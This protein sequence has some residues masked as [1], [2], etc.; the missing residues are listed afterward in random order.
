MARAV[1]F[2]RFGPTDELEVVRIPPP[3]PGPG[4]VRVHVRAAGLNPVDGKILRS[5]AAAAF[6][7][8]GG[9]PSGNGNDFAGVVDSVGDGVT[10]WSVGDE[11]YGGRRFFAQADFVVIAAE[12]LQRKPADLSWEQA[13]ALDIVGRTA[14][15]AVRTVAPTAADTV[16]VSAACG[17]VGILATQL[18]AETGARV[19][20]TASPSN[21]E[22]LRKLGVIPVAYGDGVEE[23]IREVAP[24][25]VTAVLDQHGRETIELGL[26]L[27]VD[28]ARINTIAAKPFAAEVGA[29]GRGGAEAEP[30][31]LPWIAG[32][33]AA[34]EIDFP[35]DS[36]F[37]LE[38]VRE[39]YA[40]LE[41]GHVRG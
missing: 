28:P 15:V 2:D 16:L 20:A 1:V 25:G 27:G 32:R 13:G 4:E 19:I 17:G 6:Y 40:R 14:V 31:D 34:G 33:I 9:F 5:P 41:A 29:H 21:H 22:Y 35:I 23:R 24:D 12:K 26:A 39:A 18:A 3:M 10:A 11:V 38:R 36:I 8:F 7:N 37:P 30:G